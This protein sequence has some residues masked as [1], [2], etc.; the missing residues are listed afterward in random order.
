MCAASRWLS[1]NALVPAW[2]DLIVLTPIQDEF[3]EAE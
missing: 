3:A 1:S 2:P